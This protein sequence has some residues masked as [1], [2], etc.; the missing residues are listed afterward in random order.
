VG[1]ASGSNTLDFTPSNADTGTPDVL[2]VGMQDGPAIYFTYRAS[3]PARTVQYG[4][5]TT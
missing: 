2:R 3:K 5:K 4:F 1:G